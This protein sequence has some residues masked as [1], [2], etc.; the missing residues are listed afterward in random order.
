MSSMPLRNL[1]VLDLGTFIAAPFCATI[2][3]EFGAEVIKI[4][5]PGKGD[6]LRT[7]GAAR[8]GA[9]LFWLQESRNKHTITCNLR[10]RAGQEIVR[11]FVHNGYNV[12]VENFRPGTLE[13]W[14]LGYKDLSAIDPSLIMG[15]IS[16]YGQDGP[17]KDLPG[18][19]RIAQI[20]RLG[21]DLG[22]DTDKL[23]SKPLVTAASASKNC[24]GRAWCDLVA[25]D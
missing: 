3:A 9:P 19:G 4:E 7:L 12:V 22:E 10:E 6:S 5:V 24:E 11:D 15:R 17:N 21:R 1:K 23:L 14:G 16:G 25:S 2:L 18:F 13:S 8:D 20:A